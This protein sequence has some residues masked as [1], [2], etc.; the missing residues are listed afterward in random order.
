MWMLCDGVCS[1]GKNL[2]QRIQWT[3]WQSKDKIY[4]DASIH[5]IFSIIYIC[6]LI[7]MQA[8][9]KKRERTI[10]KCGSCVCVCECMTVGIRRIDKNRAQV[11]ES[12]SELVRLCVCVRV[13]VEES[14]RRRCKRIINANGER[15]HRLSGKWVSF[16]CA[17]VCMCGEY[18]YF[19]ARY[20]SEHSLQLE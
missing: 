16:V 4:A 11:S 18:I 19:D 10:N 7:N 13:N 12:V 9:E 8:M 1:H 17:C 14:E 2:F 3:I 15:F 6:F 5:R 20:L